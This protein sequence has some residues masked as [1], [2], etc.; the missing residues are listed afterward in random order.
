MLH[1][2]ALNEAC[3]MWSAVDWCWRKPGTHSLSLRLIYASWGQIISG[4]VL[5]YKQPTRNSCP[6]PAFNPSSSVSSCCGDESNM[7]AGTLAHSHPRRSEQ[8]Q[9]D[10]TIGQTPRVL[11]NA[12]TALKPPFEG[13]RSRSEAPFNKVW[14]TVRGSG[15][16]CS[17]NRRSSSRI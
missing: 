11:S 2:V 15:R 13:Q 4:I 6:L 16:G 8:H 7:H 12:K 10:P 17:R 5:C 14:G 1:H 3:H 9:L